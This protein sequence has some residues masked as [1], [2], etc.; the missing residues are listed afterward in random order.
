MQ[1]WMYHLVMAVLLFSSSVA[2]L[3]VVNERDSLQRLRDFEAKVTTAVNTTCT[4][5]FIDCL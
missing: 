5:L 2:V 1:E 3:T 4:H